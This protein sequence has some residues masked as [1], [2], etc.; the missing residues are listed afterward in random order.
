[1]LRDEKSVITTEITTVEVPTSLPGPTPS[2][3]HVKVV[4]RTATTPKSGEPR[5]GTEELFLR[6]DLTDAG[7]RV[8]AVTVDRERR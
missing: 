2:S 1:M 3:V 7:W 6:L 4:Y 8:I 5:L